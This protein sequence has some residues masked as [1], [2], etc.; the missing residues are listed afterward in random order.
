MGIICCKHTMNDRICKYLWGSLHRLPVS[1]PNGNHTRF[2]CQV[3]GQRLA[4]DQFNDAGIH[5]VPGYYYGT[6]GT[7]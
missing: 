5:S 7:L 4:W 6:N 3:Y 1:T 2:G